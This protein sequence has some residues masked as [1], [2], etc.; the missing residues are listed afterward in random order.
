MTH[1][2]KLLQSDLFAKNVFFAEIIWDFW[3]KP[4]LLMTEAQTVN[5]IKHKDEK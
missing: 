2:M 3:L 4:L 1:R 5:K